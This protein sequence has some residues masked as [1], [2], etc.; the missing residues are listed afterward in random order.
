MRI[1]K[2]EDWNTTFGMALD[3]YTYK[4][5][6]QAIGRYPAFC[7]EKSE[8]S[9]TDMDTICRREL[10]AFFAQVTQETG[11]HVPND[12]V[13]EFRQTFRFVREIACQS[14]PAH[15]SGYN[16]AC[17][18]ALQG[19]WFKCPQSALTN[20]IV[21]YGRGAIQLTHNYNYG[22]FSLAAFADD[23]VLLLAPDR[24]A[25]E[26]ELAFLA[27]L[28][29]WMTP[30]NPKP[31]MHEVVTEFYVPN[32]NDLSRNL[33]DGFGLLTNIINGSMECNGPN[34]K[35]N[36]RAKYFE[37]WVE[38]MG[39]QDDAWSK[40]NRTCESM[41]RF[42]MAGSS[43]S[44]TLYYQYDAN[45]D[46]IA[47]ERADVKAAEDAL[48]KAAKKLREFRRADPDGGVYETKSGASYVGPLTT[49]LLLAISSLM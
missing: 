14:N 15:C 30:Q 41:Q 10:A 40:K 27:S 17:S 13:P 8:T 29:F 34:D 18:S 31:S 23:Q 1:L 45:N 4:N 49:L 21:Y 44:R 35:A 28:W 20:E 47:K 32:A 24:V 9:S 6:L 25:A 39:L 16:L 11:G 3:I 42:D 43:G 26:G 38:F 19:K 5:F 36:T 2:E 12:P 48:L 7:G 22:R 46:D 37:G 33:V